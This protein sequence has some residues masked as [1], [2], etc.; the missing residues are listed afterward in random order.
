[1]GL[2][3]VIILKVIEMRKIMIGLC[4]CMT[5]ALLTACQSVNIQ[6][7]E[8]H[9]M[10]PFDTQFE[11][12]AYADDEKTFD[13]YAKLVQDAFTHYHQLYDQYHT[14]EGINNI[15]TINDAAGDHA[16][17]VDDE[18]F[19]LLQISI[20]YNHTYS[21]QVNIA[22]GPVLTLWHD[23]RESNDPK[24]PDI[25]SLTN[26]NQYC[27]ID[28]IQLDENAQTVYLSEPGMSLDV[29]AIAKGYACE[30]VKKQLIDAGCESFLISAGGNVVSYGQRLVKAKESSLSKVL[31]ACID[32]FTV[33]VQSPGDGAYTNVTNTVAIVLDGQSVVTSGDYQRYFTAPDGTRYHHL[34]DPQTLYPANYMRSVTIVTENSGL[35]DFLSSAV[36]LMPVE[37]GQELIESLDG[38][39]AVWLCND[40]TVLFSSGLIEGEN[41]HL[42]DS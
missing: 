3:C 35:A 41:F 9:F 37:D 10:G 24:V 18:I 15:K 11:F 1:M 39:E 23:A 5:F 21:S 6:M 12:R 29:G 4:L 36:F 40:G 19:D 38:V 27:D 13:S 32:Q 42:Y 25:S 20:E 17:A 22:F 26:A 16:V 7:Y 2:S 14:Y 33:G 30:L 8:S 28:K 34:I 31:P